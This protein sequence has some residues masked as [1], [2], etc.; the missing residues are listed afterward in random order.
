MIK[1]LK[2]VKQAIFNSYADPANFSTDP[3]SI[4]NPAFKFHI[5]NTNS[6]ETTAYSCIR[7]ISESASQLPHEII[8]TSNQQNTPA[9]GNPLYN[10]LTYKPN[11]FQTSFDYW[12]YHYCSM[13]EHGFALSR[14][15]TNREGKVIGLLPFVPSTVKHTITDTGTLIFKGKTVIDNIN[16]RPDT[17]ITSKEAFYKMYATVDGFTPL[18]PIQANK[19]SINLSESMRKQSS[20]FIHNNA[21]K[22]AS[23]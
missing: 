20:N 4:Y 15:I 23:L 8:N 5:N 10:V 21:Q 1:Y 12:K 22:V 16:N 13:L 7:V 2:R 9:T 18:S 14:K 6:I 17:T 3:F 19:L 11:E